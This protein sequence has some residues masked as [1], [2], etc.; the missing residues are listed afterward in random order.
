M[1]I[2]YP[3]KLAFY[4]LSEP[5]PVKGILSY[6]LPSYE[7]FLST[8]S[9]GPPTR[10]WVSVLNIMQQLRAFCMGFSDFIQHG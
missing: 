7:L 10:N 3:D 1:C 6:L 4:F 2:T 8:K 9:L 5:I